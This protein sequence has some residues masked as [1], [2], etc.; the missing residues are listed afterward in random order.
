MRVPPGRDCHLTTRPDG[1]YNLAF[2]SHTRGP[3]GPERPTADFHSG[4]YAGPSGRRGL[5]L[6]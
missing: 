4:H 5:C 6:S 2:D 3:I 1:T